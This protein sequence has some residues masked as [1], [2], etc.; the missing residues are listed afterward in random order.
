MPSQTDLHALAERLNDRQRAYLLAAYGEDQLRE[1]ANKGRM[2]APPAR[3]WR[4][5][6]YGPVGL[7]ALDGHA[8]FLLRR[9]LERDGL[10]DQ[11]TGATWAALVAAG[12]VETRHAN[13]GFVDR[14]SRR[15][16]LSL[17]VKMTTPGRKVARVLRGEPLT[18]TRV[19]KPLGLAALRLVAHGQGH[20]DKEFHYA[21][22]WDVCPLDHLAMRGVCLGLIKRGLLAGE[23]PDQLRITEAGRALEV[24][25]EPNWKPLRRPSG[26]DGARA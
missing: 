24:V 19:E 12:L 5:I 18:R 17:L 2:G 15:P 10:V 3:V 11:G 4:W 1:A 7:R 6:E 21:D 13:T 22:P 16:I 14:R 20:P 25:K 23:F 8:A 26:A 9:E